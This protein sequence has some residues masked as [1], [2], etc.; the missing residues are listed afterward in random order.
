GHKPKTPGRFQTY[1]LFT[2]Y[3]EQASS[4]AED[5][6]FYFFK[7]IFNSPIN[8]PTQAGRPSRL[9]ARAVRSEAIE[10]RNSVRTKLNQSR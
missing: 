7:R 5:A 2:M 3:S 8:P 1:L 9:V 10:D 6:N 4:L